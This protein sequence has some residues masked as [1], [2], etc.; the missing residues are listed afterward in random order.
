MHVDREPE[1]D[2]HEIIPF[3]WLGSVD[4]MLCPAELRAR[5]IRHIVSVLSNFEV[6]IIEKAVC[7]Y[8]CRW[9][10][11]DCEDTVRANLGSFFV[12][13]TKFIEKAIQSKE[14]VLVHCYAGVSR[15]VAV[16]CAYLICSLG[17][18][19]ESALALTQ[20]KRPVA[21]PNV[22]FRIALEQ[23]DA[24]RKKRPCNLL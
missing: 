10:H 18:D 22:G 15:S 9:L 20:S 8:D 14:G 6:N 7:D 11:I 1:W 12:S 24:H 3:L 21:C 4:C 19:V 23:F 5:N 2:A 13:T 16:V 17:L